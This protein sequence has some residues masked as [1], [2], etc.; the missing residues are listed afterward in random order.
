VGQGALAVQVRADDGEAMALARAI[1]HRETRAACE[2]ERAFLERLGAGCEQPVGA[3]ASVDSGEFH[4]R[5]ML[6]SEDGLSIARRELFGAMSEA[7]ALGARL[8]E[9]LLGV[10][11]GPAPLGD[12]LLT[13]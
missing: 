3:Y 1:D 11:P 10:A 13:T 4:V 5:A 12:E 8:A 7:R 2:A 6:A 9:E